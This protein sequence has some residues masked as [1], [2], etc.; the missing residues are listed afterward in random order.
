MGQ[1]NQMFRSTCKYFLPFRMLHKW[2][3]QYVLNKN[4]G[5]NAYEIEYL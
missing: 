3:P 4:E 5:P 2:F 1:A